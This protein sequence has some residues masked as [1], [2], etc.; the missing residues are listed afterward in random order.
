MQ[1]R[2]VTRHMPEWTLITLYML[3]MAG[4]HVDSATAV[5]VEWTA[6]AIQSTIRQSSTCVGVHKER[7]WVYEHLAV[8]TLVKPPNVLTLCSFFG[9]ASPKLKRVRVCV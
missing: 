6:T 8:C 4:A 2:S 1:W 7:G 3:Q 9:R 5:G